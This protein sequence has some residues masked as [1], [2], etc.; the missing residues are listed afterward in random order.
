MSSKLVKQSLHL[1]QD[2]PA[3][4]DQDGSARALHSRS[5][6]AILAHN[7]GVKKRG[8]K[9]K[10]A[11]DSKLTERRTQLLLGKAGKQGLKRQRQQQRKNCIRGQEERIERKLRETDPIGLLRLEE[12]EQEER[13]RRNV[14]YLKRTSLVTLSEIKARKKILERVHAEAAARRAARD[15]ARRAIEQAAADASDDEW[16]ALD[17]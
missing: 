4:G 1:L 5:S 7:G 3:G 9:N 17:V 2:A 10:R 6:A 16:A 12:Q 11:K 15:H 8:A 14:D 13:L